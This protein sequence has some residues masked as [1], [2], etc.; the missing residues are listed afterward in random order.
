VTFVARLTIAALALFAAIAVWAFGGLNGFFAVFALAL[1]TAPGYPIG[2]ALFGRRHAAGWIAGALFGY[3]ITAFV[4]WGVVFLRIP[5]GAIFATVWLGACGASWA[6]F[7][8]FTS[9]AAMLP[10]WSS[11]DTIAL[12]LLLLLVP[13]LV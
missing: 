10:L 11:R 9:P 8:R 12:A 1:A 2:F 3:A 7:R 6:A 13:A 4:C 5:S